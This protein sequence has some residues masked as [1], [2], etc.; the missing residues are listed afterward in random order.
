MGQPVGMKQQAWTIGALLDWTAQHFTTRGSEYPRLDAEVLLAHAL[1]CRRIDLYTR[2]QETASEQGRARFRELVRQRLE[3]CPVAYLVGRKEFFSLKFEVTPA[4]LI[5]RPES[6]FVVLEC[7]HLARELAEPRILDIG[8]GSGNL[9]VTV[10]HQQPRAQVTAV[11]LSPDALAVASR[12]AVHHGVAD[13]I[14]FL[15]GDLLD[16]LPRDERFDFILSNPPYI[17]HEDLDRLPVGVRN[18]EPLLALDGGPGGFTVFG[19]LVA[20]AVD[21]LVPGGHLIIEIGAPQH[22]PARQRI[23]AQGQYE[24]ADTIYDGSRHP[25]VLRARKVG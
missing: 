19:R 23:L 12:N 17:A 18:Y 6:E 16:P 22:E 7:L 21:Y 25:R 3:G 1:E 4:V 2:Y 10:A 20:Q 15:S 11:D 13:R 5:P 14:R 24:L 9:A 8:T